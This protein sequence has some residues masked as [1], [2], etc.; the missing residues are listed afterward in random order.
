MLEKVYGFKIY[1]VS[2]DGLPMPNGLFGN[3]RLDQGQAALLGVE[4][5]PALFL[6]KPPRQIVS[7]TQGALSLEVVVCC[8]FRMRQVS[9]RCRFDD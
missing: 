4:Q 9:A 5:T 2:L 7:L 6:I 8:L 3:F 1:P